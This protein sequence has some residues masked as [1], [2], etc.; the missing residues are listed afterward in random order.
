MH[1]QA[2]DE[3][4][5]FDGLQVVPTRFVRACADGH[6]DDID[7]RRFV[8]G[9][10]DS[11]RRPLWL[12]E[13]GITG[14]LSGLMVRCECKK[15][16]RLD[17]ATRFELK[18]LG[19]CSG[20]RP[21]LGRYAREK[22]CGQ[23]GRLLIR[24]AT[25][26]YF[27]QKV[28]VLAI[29]EASE[30][31]ETVER[32]WDD[33]SIVDGADDLRFIK[34]K[35]KIVAALAAFADRE[36]LKAISE[37]KGGLKEDKPVKQ[38][39]LDALL[40][41]K[42][43]YG[44]DIP[45]DRD[46]HVRRLPEHVWRHSRF[47]RKGTKGHLSDGI[48]AV[49]QLHRLREVLALT[50]F[51]RFDPIMPDINGEYDKDIELSPLALD[52]LW[53]PAIENRGE[54]LFLQLRGDAVEEWVTRPAVVARLDQLIAGH[55]LWKKS[56]NSKRD[57][58]NGPYVLLHTL[59]H[60]MIQSLAMRCGYPASSIRERIYAD[61]EAGRYGLLLYTG[62]PDAEGTLGGLV[63]QAR[64]VESHLDHALRTGALC[65][66]DPICAQH[67]PVGSLEERWLHG[68]ACH[69]CAL[70]AEPSCEMH[71]DYLDR[72]PVVPTLADDGAAFFG[73]TR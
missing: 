1:R 20:A 36:V 44:D 19:G 28:S 3:K 24:T 22:G 45:I 8:H 29:P 65:S 69:G 72:A 15:S 70:L 59:S 7:W 46:F 52:P 60:L 62:T 47:P 9:D 49:I 63:S 5:R 61:Y 57:F 42:R 68:A 2:L 17:E 30:V 32:L 35:P 4:S 71:T 66:N 40:A 73:G 51:T 16:R 56:R 55:E 25:S 48:E 26:A 37:I 18:P 11:C 64:H 27:P 50:G 58:P 12:D 10:E 33:L 38:V 21:W 13:R 53:F 34:K 54:G 67:A 14:D 39:E 41:A 6:V 23:P 43:G 31:K